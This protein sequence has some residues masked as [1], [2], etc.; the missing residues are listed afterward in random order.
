MSKA[1]IQSGGVLQGNFG[2]NPNRRTFSKKQREA[3]RNNETM[4]RL[5]QQ[6][7]SC[8]DCGR[9]LDQHGV[10]SG[11]PHLVSEDEGARLVCGGCQRNGDYGE[12]IRLFQHGTH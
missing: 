5:L 4:F 1:A 2:R 9:S 11:R 3:Q 12:P 8:T 6:S 10:F 7:R